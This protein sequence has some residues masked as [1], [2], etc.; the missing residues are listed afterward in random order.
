M[1]TNKVDIIANNSLEMNYR[2]EKIDQ[3]EIG[4]R[5]RLLERLN[6][7]TYMDI[8]LRNHIEN[9][10]SG[11][12]ELLSLYGRLFE[13]GM[14][15]SGFQF[16]GLIV[17][18]KPKGLREELAYFFL[19]LGFFSSIFAALIAFISIEFFKSMK[20]EDPEYVVEGCMKYKKFFR[21]ADMTLFLDTGLFLISLN[22]AVYSTLRLSF[23]I[24]LNVIAGLLVMFLAGCHFF[25]VLRKQIFTVSGGRVLKRNIYADKSC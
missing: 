7:H 3:A 13:Y 6:G 22:I 20:N 17:E 5:Q 12:E 4:L 21:L 19:G 9:I 11:I 25:I 24:A 8:L 16:V 1:D 18:N 23:S 15:L 10:N 14:F 2:D